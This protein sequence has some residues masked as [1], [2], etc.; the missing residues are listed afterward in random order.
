[1]KYRRCCCRTLANAGVVA[2]VPRAVRRNAAG[3]VGHHDDTAVH[4]SANAPPP[5]RHR[6]ATSPPPHRHRTAT[7]PPPLRHRTATA[8]PPHRHWYLLCF[9]GCGQGPSGLSAKTSV[10]LPGKICH[11][12]LRYVTLRYVTLRYVTLR[13]G[14]LARALRSRLL[15]YTPVKQIPLVR[16][17][18]D[19]NRFTLTPPSEHVPSRGVSAA[20]ATLAIMNPR[21]NPRRH[22]LQYVQ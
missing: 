7:A 12:T 11:L 2:A 17:R 4:Q 21:V 3:G 20:L 15:P 13:Y 8:P 16:T 9:G 18:G 14:P 5:H 6:T 10:V 1:M 22:D 19:K